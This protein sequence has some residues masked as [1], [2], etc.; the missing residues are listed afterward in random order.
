MY[1]T[2]VLCCGTEFHS[3][4]LVWENV[5]YGSRA[6]KWMNYSV[7]F[8]ILTSRWISNLIEGALIS[9]IKL[10]KVDGLSSNSIT[11]VP[12]CAT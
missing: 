12:G 4:K 6:S 8:W 1:K 3:E 7:F 11:V 10:N 9:T 5:C 2:E